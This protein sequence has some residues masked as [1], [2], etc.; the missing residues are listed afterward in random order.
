MTEF[1]HVKDIALSHHI[2][3]MVKKYKDIDTSEYTIVDN[4][5]F[6]LNTERL[7]R[8]IEGVR[9]GD[10]IPSIKLKKRYGKHE[11]IDGRHRIAVALILGTQLITSSFYSV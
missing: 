5:T 4:G 10:D 11:V 1:I 2:I 3:N 7:E 9:N 8:I 6:P